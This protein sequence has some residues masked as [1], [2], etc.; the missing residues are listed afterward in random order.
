MIHKQ[1]PYTLK[2]LM[3]RK[4]GRSKGYP[5]QTIQKILRNLVDSSPLFFGLAPFAPE[6]AAGPFDI[7]D[8][9]RDKLN[10][11]YN[12]T[13]NKYYFRRKREYHDNKN[14]NPPHLFR[15]GQ[16]RK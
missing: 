14:K 13:K 3:N 4:A 9:F 15:S 6:R 12:F 1:T 8:S 7:P 10:T 2:S 16:Y 11:G 5:E